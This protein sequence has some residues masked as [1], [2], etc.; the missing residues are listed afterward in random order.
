MMTTLRLRRRDNQTTSPGQQPQGARSLP[1][2]NHSCSGCCRAGRARRH[3]AVSSTMNHRRIQRPPP[4]PRILL[5]AI[6]TLTVYCCCHSDYCSNVRMWHVQAL[7][8]TTFNVLAAVHRSVP[9]AMVNQIEQQQQQSQSS[10][11]SQSPP[12]P[13]SLLVPLQQV[14][15]RRE[16]ERRDWWQPRAE[17]LAQFVAKEL[18]RFTTGCFFFSPLLRILCDAR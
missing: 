17:G 12:L 16:S 4:P 1:N 9:M 7:S 15:N 8:V 11:S 3:S 13:S 14:P 6:V 18:V 10:S 2:N 5:S